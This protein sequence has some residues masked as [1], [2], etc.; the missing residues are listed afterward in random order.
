LKQLLVLTAFVLAANSAISTRATAQAISKEPYPTKPIR[1]VV[2]FAP[3]GTADFLARVIGEKLTQRLHQTVIID[4]RPGAGGNIGMEIVARSPADG[5]T[6]VLAMVGSWAM[7]P[8]LY[9]LSYDVVNDFAPIIHV[10]AMPGVLVVH[11]SV[12]VKTVKEY[13]ALARQRPGELTYGTAGVGTFAHVSGELLSQMTGVKLTHV[14]YKGSGP[15][16]LD[17][18][19]GHISSSFESITPTLPY[20]TAGRVRALATTGATRS[21]VLPDLPTIAEAGV[22]GFDNPTWAAIG[23]PARTPRPIIE[24]LNEE[25]NAILQMPEFK[26]AIR[27]AGGNIT[28]GTPEQFR[29]YLRLELAKF[30]KLI[31]DTGMKVGG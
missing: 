30:G 12:P 4:N 3:G 31:K 22:P 16:L 6:I 7:N 14:P 2:P 27:L 19:G 15:A 25:I 10:A 11:P 5:H 29:D 23:A 24:R 8:H 28:G 1:F 17:L 18:V 21:Q 13:V 9:K 20:I 26:E